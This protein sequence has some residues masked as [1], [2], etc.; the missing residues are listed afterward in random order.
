V[1]ECK[2]QEVLTVAPDRLNNFE[3][4]TQKF[5][6][7]HLHEEEEIRFILDGIGTILVYSKMV[8]DPALLTSHV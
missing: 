2:S 5:F 7:E 8:V 1:H 3:A 6:T 4:L